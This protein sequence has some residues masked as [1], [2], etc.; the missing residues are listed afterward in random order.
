VARQVKIEILGD[1]SKLRSA[2]REAERSTTGFGKGIARAGVFAATGLAGIATGV[3]V[4]A[5]KSIQ[6]AQESN[7]VS[8]QTEAA[9][10]STG[11]AAKITAKQVGDLATAISN[12]TGI[13]DEQIQSSENMLLTFTNVRNA[14]GK[15]NDIFTQAT[16][17]LQDMSVALGV[18]SSQAAIQ[19][20]KALNDPIKGVTALQRV[21]VTFTE[22]Q[23]KQI[24]TLVDSGKTMDAQRIILKELGKEFGGSA[25]AAATPLDKLKV[26]VGNLQEKIGNK[27]LPTVNHFANLTITKVVPAISKFIDQAQDFWEVHGPQL[28]DSLADV[29]FQIRQLIDPTTQ[30]NVKLHR[31]SV[32]ADDVAAKLNELIVWVGKAVIWF[33]HAG[34]A[35]NFAAKYSDF[36]GTALHLRL[37]LAFLETAEIAGTVVKWILNIG[38]AAGKTG[39]VIDRFSGGSGHAFDSFVA[40]A[41][42][43]RDQTESQLGG[44]RQDIATTKRS[45]AGLHAP[46]LVFSAEDHVNPVVSQ[47]M[48]EMKAR[49]FSVTARLVR[50]GTAQK[51]TRVPGYGGGDRHPYMLEGGETVVPKE[52]TPEIAPWAA[53]RG[54]PGFRSGGIVPRS[55]PANVNL[56][57]SRDALLSRITFGP[58]SPTNVSGAVA[59]GKALAAQMG[60]VG[61]QWN[62]LYQLWQHESGWRWN[63]DNP[64]SSAYGIPQALPGSKMASVASDWRTN[65]RTQILWGE[66]YIKDRYNNPGNA[67]AAWL[68]RSP[69]WY[70]NGGYLP[71]GLSLAY[72]GTGRPEPVGGGGIVVNVIVRGALIGGSAKEIAHDLAPAMREGIRQAMRR[73]G[74][75][76]GGI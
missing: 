29:L 73:E 47:I 28:R 43:M 30:F 9:I 52:L 17:I 40:D 10:K 33:R 75:N 12:K 63:A 61:A 22:Q 16:S 18:D 13:D 49:G 48:R 2:F 38:I 3:G 26:V 72:N 69:H 37:K 20:G 58:T 59:L 56:T 42:N 25:E 24:K 57:A 53:A 62:A 70:D 41:R 74:R 31:V 23:K 15:N 66:G 54:I 64:T 19:L 35:L 7:K 5:F 68:G 14:A 4:A 11:G 45:I 8:K 50:G 76:P 39:N 51:G 34:E 6:A 65:P 32:S 67:W 44:I 21:G 71:P 36:L 46:K 27:L 55:W 1:A 60:W